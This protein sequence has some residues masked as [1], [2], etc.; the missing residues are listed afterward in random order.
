MRY[1][2]PSAVRTEAVD[3]TTTAA[4]SHTLQRVTTAC[5]T[6]VASHTRSID[7]VAVAIMA[8]Q[9]TDD[10]VAAMT[11][12]MITTDEVVTVVEVADS[13]TRR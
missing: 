4:T 1:S 8:D 9:T 12:V 3:I 10:L 7:L 13:R 2:V 11:V 6:A 5:T